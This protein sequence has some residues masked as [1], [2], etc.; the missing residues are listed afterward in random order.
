MNGYLDFAQQIIKDKLTITNP[1]N[2]FE[3]VILSAYC[4]H[5]ILVCVKT[6]MLSFFSNSYRTL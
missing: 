4:L 6:R 1:E 2:E 3:N 5:I